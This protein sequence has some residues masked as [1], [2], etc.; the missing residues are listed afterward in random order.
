MEMQTMAI[1]IIALII[2]LVVINRKRKFDIL[3]QED[4]EAYKNAKLKINNLK[5]DKKIFYIVTIITIIVLVITLVIVSE[6]IEKV[7]S[8]NTLIGR[9][10]PY[11]S[12]L[13]KLFNFTISLITITISLLFIAR[14]IFEYVF[15]KKKI[16]K[17]EELSE[18]EKEL[19]N[20]FYI[21]PIFWYIAIGIVL[22]VIVKFIGSIPSMSRMI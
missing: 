21:K 5:K 20:E 15:I 17:S 9:P 14:G 10:G 2:A 1:G 6:V 4:K 19:L 16:N 12:P 8:R 18:K 13:E 11:I 7:N 3:T 22:Y